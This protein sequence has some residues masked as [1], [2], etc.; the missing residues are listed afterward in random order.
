MPSA[1]ETTYMIE[2]IPAE[3]GQDLNSED[4]DVLISRLNEDLRLSN[5]KASKSSSVNRSHKRK[6]TPY[7]KKMRLLEQQKNNKIIDEIDDF[8][9][10]QALL[11]SGALINEAVKRLKTEKNF[12]KYDMEVSK[13]NFE[14]DFDKD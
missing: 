12:K 1:E 14:M 2:M 10:F 11:R 5:L 8:E 7:Q 6:I 13:W 4:V 9:R 3:S